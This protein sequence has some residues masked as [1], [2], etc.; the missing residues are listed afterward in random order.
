MNSTQQNTCWECSTDK[1]LWNQDVFNHKQL[2]SLNYTLN[3][4]PPTIDMTNH[5][6]HDLNFNQR[7]KRHFTEILLVSNKNH[8]FNKERN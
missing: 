1:M 7:G 4:E 3:R 2:I 8:H 5:I 6:H